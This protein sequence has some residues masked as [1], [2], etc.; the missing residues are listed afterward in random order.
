M[1]CIYIYIYKYLFI[2]LHECYTVNREKLQKSIIYMIK[3]NH[4]VEQNGYTTL[5]YDIRNFMVWYVSPIS[6]GLLRHNHR[7]PRTC[8]T[9]SG[10]FSSHPVNMA[11]WKPWTIEIGDFPSYKRP[12]HWAFS[13]HVW[14]PEG[15]MISMK[16][17]VQCTLHSSP[18]IKTHGNTNNSCYSP[19]YGYMILYRII[20]LYPCVIGLKYPHFWIRR[21]P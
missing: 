1:Y 7:P 9:W 13:S 17:I 5:Q 15:R 20:Y 6:T 12:W 21:F 4:L 18:L 3:N 10:W 14:L 8:C 2:Y 11:C 19:N 16:L